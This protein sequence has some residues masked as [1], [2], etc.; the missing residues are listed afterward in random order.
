MTYVTDVAL[1]PLDRKVFPDDIA[2]SDFHQA[3]CHLVRGMVAQTLTCHV[4]SNLVVELDECRIHER[5]F[6]RLLV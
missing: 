2:W 3:W 1:P 6:F 4:C 5:I